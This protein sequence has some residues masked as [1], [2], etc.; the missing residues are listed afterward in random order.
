MIY[1]ELKL[2][3]MIIET[4]GNQRGNSYLDAEPIQTLNLFY[5]AQV[6]AVEMAIE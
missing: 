5:K 3:I 1:I 4:I 6:V 2:S